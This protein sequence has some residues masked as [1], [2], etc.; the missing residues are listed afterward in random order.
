MITRLMDSVAVEVMRTPFVGRKTEIGRIEKLL[1]RTRKGRG[2]ALLVL[3]PAGIGKTRLLSEAKRSAAHAGYRVA[4]AACLPLVTPLPYEPILALLRTLRTGGHLTQTPPPVRLAPDALFA[5]TLAALEQVVSHGPVLLCVD[6][7]HDSDQATLELIQYCV[8]RLA[9]LPLAWLLAARPASRLAPFLHH[10]GRLELLD[11]LELPALSEEELAEVAA[12]LLGEAP[13]ADV[14]AHLYRRSGANTFL[15]VELV[16]ALAHAPRIS[17]SSQT[18]T[19]SVPASVAES[20]AARRRRLPP[21]ASRL[22]DWLAIFPE[23]T[24]TVWLA[25]VEPL[26]ERELEAALD[27]LVDEGLVERLQDGRSRLVHALLRDAVYDAIAPHQR[28]GRHAKA[29]SALA[30][31]AAQLRAPQLE[32]AARSTEAAAAYLELAEEAFLRSAG[33]DAGALYRR[34]ERLAE[35]GGERR[36]R[37]SAIAGQVLA[38]LR[39]GADSDA[40]PLADTLIGELRRAGENDLLLRFLSR[41]ALALFDDASDV[42]AARAALA[43]AEPLAVHASAPDLARAELAQAFVLTMAGEPG[44]ALPHAERALALARETDDP[45]LEVQA[46]DRLG[47]VLGMGRGSE[48]ATPLLTEAIDR[49]LA[50]DL[51]A[52]A[53]HALLNLS[54]FSDAAGDAAAA[55]DYARQGLDV[56]G[57]PPSMEVLLRSNLGGAL[58]DLGDLDGA[59]AQQ[60]AARAQA[61]RISPKLEARILVTLAHV[62][63]LRGELDAAHAALDEIKPAPGS[64]E[65]YRTLE[66]R[67]LLLECEGRLGDALARYLESTAASDHPSA[68]WCAVGAIRTAVALGERSAAH[69]AARTLEHLT[70]RWAGTDWLD[71]EARGFLAE[72]AGAPERA[73]ALLQAAAESCPSR[74]HRTRLDAESARLRRDRN[75][76]L[77]AIDTFEQ[78]GARGAADRTRRLARKLGFRPGRRRRPAGVL[79]QR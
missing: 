35:A 56:E 38:Q 59:L 1:E 9:D 70:G 15:Y 16:R 45:L 23:P 65:H 41:Y 74:F 63:I 39:L 10:L 48:Q 24:S 36:L 66:Q 54:Y 20:V 27:A 75:G 31:A 67:A 71:Q 26:A 2:S 76:L 3:G 22:L 77:A 79:S 69:K 55:A 62:H 40:R 53:A 47:F 73:A 52:E 17:S 7:L 72:L 49:A 14:L 18:T 4:A 78:M 21:V 11:R 28:P 60:L 51:P 46:L 6:D 29:A 32:A 68:L 42:E 34:A 33:E 25:R 61:S 13:S 58:A 50:A 37:G 57:L 30:D 8:V 12:A 44:P 43:H 19:A 64:F 5:R